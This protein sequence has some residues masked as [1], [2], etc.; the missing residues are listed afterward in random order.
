MTRKGDITGFASVIF[1]V[2]LLVLLQHPLS[3]QEIARRFGIGFFGG[4]VKMVGGEVD[5]STIDQ[6]AGFE[7]RYGYTEWVSFNCDFG[8]GWV[9]ARDPHGSQFA[10]VSGFKT[11]L[12]PMNISVNYYLKPESRFRTYLN[13]GGM[14][15]FINQHYVLNFIFNYHQLIKEA[16]DTIGLG[17]DANH[18]IIEL[19]LGLSYLWGGF[20]DLDGD[21]IDDRYDL[22]PQHK[23]D[24]DGFQDDDGAPDPDNDNDGIPD[25]LD[26]APLL[27]EDI[28][29]F[30]D[31]DG[32]PDL[33]N[34]KDNIVDSLDQ[35]PDIP[36]DFDE[37]EDTDGCPEWDNDKDG[38][39]DSVDQCVNWPEDF[40]DY[41]DEDGCPDEK[42]ES[43]FLKI[44]EKI[45][46]RQIRFIPPNQLINP[47]SYIALDEIYKMM[48]DYPK[49]E[50][51]IRSYTDSSGNQR[52]N[53]LL[54]QKRAAAIKNY[55]MKRGIQ[56]YRLKAIGLGSAD[57][58]ADNS[59][60]E[61][62]AANRRIEFV[63]IK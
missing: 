7:I 4:A 9:R 6:W 53:L 22:D 46:T 50:I 3:A 59:T 26:K 18:A 8:Y 11:I 54:S 24:F 33:D 14:E 1:I 28:D 57:P 25:E 2:S 42:P 10:S 27:A 16:E 36:E 38:I 30:Q 43:D 44:G 52:I 32:V 48:I 40:N 55:L 37:F 21:R 56:G 45:V 23:E 60:P 47:S 12:I 51:E 61:G 58:I 39:P 5:R 34:D 62:R 29:G 31:E 35:C 41:L 15:Y 19:R 17:D 13:F 49:I 63:R 20:R